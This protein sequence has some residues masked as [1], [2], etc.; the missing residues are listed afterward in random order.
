MGFVESIKFLIVMI[1][2]EI[3]RGFELVGGTVLMV[4]HGL[5]FL[6]TFFS[7]WQRCLEQAYIIGYRTLPIVTVMSFFIGAVLALQTG[8]SLGSV[9][10][11][12]GFL[13]NIVGLSMCRELGPVMT[14]FLL[15]GRCGSSIGAEIGAMRVYQELDALHTMGISPYR[16]LVFP[17]LVGVLIMMPI[18]TMFAII[19]GWWGGQVVSEYVGFITLS[20]QLYW[21]GILESVKFKS[22]MD[23]LVKAEIFGLVAVAVACYEGFATS[24][25]PREIGRSVTRSVVEGMVMILVLDYVVTKCQI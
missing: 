9:Q 14:A 19:L 5:R 10:G 15:A 12:S 20:P 6:P 25:G 3:K 21:R 23:G 7:G 17:R 18:L 22:V 1:T 16:F 2:T 24:G 8:Y 11:A 4:F 13:G